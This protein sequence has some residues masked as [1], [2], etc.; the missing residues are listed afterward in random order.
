MSEIQQ[1]RVIW[2]E[3]MFKSQILICLY[4]AI[5]CEHTAT[6]GLLW[7]NITAHW[8]WMYWQAQDA[9]HY[10]LRWIQSQG[11]AIRDRNVS[12]S[13]VVYISWGQQSAVRQQL[14]HSCTPFLTCQSL[15]K[16]RNTVFVCC[17]SCLKSSLTG[18]RHPGC[19]LPAAE[20][21]FWLRISK[22]SKMVL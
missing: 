7:N 8:I 10:I 3:V 12:K 17:L 16:D 13:V 6:G 9:H 22:K 20:S 19:S 1:T 18:G 4:W 2:H 5:S 21:T 14:W 15:F 11:D